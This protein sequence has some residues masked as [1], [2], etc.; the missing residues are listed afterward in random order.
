MLTMGLMGAIKQSAGWAKRTLLGDSLIR[1]M[2][3]YYRIG[4]KVFDQLAQADLAISPIA[5][6]HILPRW[7]SSVG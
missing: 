6:G 5:F 7:T 4:L 3:P 2:P 1:R